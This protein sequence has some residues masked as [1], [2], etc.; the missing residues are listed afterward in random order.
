MQNTLTTALNF[1]LSPIINQVTKVYNWETEYVT[2]VAEEYVKF[3]II[4]FNKSDASP[5]MA[6]DN[7]WHQHIL[8][9]KHYAKFC[10]VC[11]NRFIHHRPEDAVDQEAQRRRLENT[12]SEYKQL[13]AVYYPPIIWIDAFYGS[14]GP[15]GATGPT[16]PC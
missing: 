14:L 3:M 11:F 9:T 15:T 6:I 13:Y 2:R 16:G 8:N 7:F 4:R 1:D 10:N 12:L 5:S